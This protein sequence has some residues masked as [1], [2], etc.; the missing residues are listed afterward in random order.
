MKTDTFLEQTLLK[1]I[2]Y[3]IFDYFPAKKLKNRCKRLKCKSQAVEKSKHFSVGKQACKS[4]CKFNAVFCY[5]NRANLIL[6]SF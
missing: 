2:P 6:T 4:S 3:R 5:I 1:L